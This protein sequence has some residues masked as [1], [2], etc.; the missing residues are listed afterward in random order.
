MK[1]IIM[2][3]SLY[4][5]VKLAS[6]ATKFLNNIRC[7]N[8]KSFTPNPQFLK[9]EGGLTDKSILFFGSSITYGAASHGISF[10][11]FLNIESNVHT[12]KEAISGTSLS[13]TE[14][15]TYVQRIKKEELSK[16]KYD[17][18]V[19][20]LSTNDGRL[21]KSIGE[22]KKEYDIDSFDVKTTIGAMEYIIS[23]AKL[24]WDIPVLFYTCIRKTDPYYEFLVYNLYK[25]KE[26]WDIEILDVWGNQ[27]ASEQ[28]KYDNTLFADDAHPTLKG[29]R[30]IYTPLFKEKI[31]NI[32]SKEI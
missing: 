6:S 8:K 7:G 21:N 25:L 14:R 22:I 29:Y 28:I 16:A 11:E 24:T 30:Y 5:V 31:K 10:V 17:L 19:C 15:N 12:T 1:K 26:K 32:L 9:K 2:L 4:I 23:Y 27:W 3:M 18:L 13:G 20:Q